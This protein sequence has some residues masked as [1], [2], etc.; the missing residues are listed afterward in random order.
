MKKKQLS[1]KNYDGSPIH[2]VPC[3]SCL[4]C[5]EKRR[6]DWTFRLLQEHKVSKSAFFITLTYD[7]AKNTDKVVLNLDKSDVQLFIKR[8]RKIHNQTEDKFKRY[9][10][11]NK[12]KKYRFPLRY[13]LVG[14]YGSKTYRP[15]YHAI[16]FNPDKKLMSL[17]E[18]IWSKGNVHIGTVNQSS[19]HYTTKY[20]INKEA[21]KDEYFKPFSIMS[22]GIGSNYFENAQMHV[23]NEELRVRNGNA[24]IPMPRYYKDRMFNESELKV[25]NKK[26]L[27]DVIDKINK[28]REKIIN[29]GD[30]PDNIENTAIHNR[31]VRAGKREKKSK[32]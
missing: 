14:E 16:I 29:T 28:K 20:I 7:D 10:I 30:N 13:Y 24:K 2:H 4:A 3:G 23:E 19:I 21:F 27:K 25:L 5:L 18:E 9:T 12:K 22:K 1:Y 32:F 8:L 31:I 6:A 15:H 17:I 26:N 11:V